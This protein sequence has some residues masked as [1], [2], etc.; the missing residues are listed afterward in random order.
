MTGVE[1]YAHRIS[2][3]AFNGNLKDGFEVARTHECGRKDCVN[4]KFLKPSTHSQS[5]F[6]AHQGRLRSR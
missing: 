5:L 3:I 6:R 1:R 2:F 4:P